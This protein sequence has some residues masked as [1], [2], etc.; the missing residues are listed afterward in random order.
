MG[1]DLRLQTNSIQTENKLKT[2]LT[3]DT[4][5]AELIKNKERNLEN[6]EK[7][8]IRTCQMGQS[9]VMICKQCYSHGNTVCPYPTDSFCQSARNI[10]T[11][12]MSI[13]WGF[14]PNNNGLFSDIKNGSK[15]N[16]TNLTNISQLPSV[17]RN[18]MFKVYD[19]S[20]VN[21]H[22]EKP[23]GKATDVCGVSGV[24]SNQ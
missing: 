17:L 23:S 10:D 21:Y 2:F 22:Y 9:W 7:V 3:D 19:Y 4:I 14:L 16:I 1:A 18:E 20:N 12:D 15:I 5:Q 11:S 13:F 8:L 24:V 6:S